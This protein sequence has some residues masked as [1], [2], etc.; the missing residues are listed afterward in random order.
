MWYFNYTLNYLLNDLFNLNNL[1][2][3][4]ENLEDIVYINKSHDLDVDHFD[5]TLVN[6]ENSTGASLYFL[7]F[8]K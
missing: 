8:F 2:Y 1:R 5:N 3:D 4:F 7:K 6:L